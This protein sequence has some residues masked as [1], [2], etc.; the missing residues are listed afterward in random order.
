MQ[1]TCK[2]LMLWT[3]HLQKAAENILPVGKRQAASDLLKDLLKSKIRLLEAPDDFTCAGAWRP[4]VKIGRDR[5][6][7][8]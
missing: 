6:I 2:K 3:D 5:Q 4:G 1:S 8:A 7:W